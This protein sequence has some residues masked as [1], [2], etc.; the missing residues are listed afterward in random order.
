ML[1]KLRIKNFLSCED[2]TI[3]FSDDITALVGRNAAGK[4][5]ILKAIN[6]VAG[7]FSGKDDLIRELVNNEKES[8]FELLME[9]EERQYFYKLGTKKKTEKELEVTNSPSLFKIT[10]QLYTIS[11]SSK[12][13][14]FNREGKDLSVKREFTDQNTP[15]YSAAS[16]LVKA[17]Y[18]PEVQLKFVLSAHYSVSHFIHSMFAMSPIVEMVKAIYD[19]L[20]KTHYY[21]LIEPEGIDSIAIYRSSYNEWLEEYNKE[22]PSDTFNV[23]RLLHLYKENHDTFGEIVNLLGDMTLGLIVNIDISEQVIKTKKEDVLYVFQ[24]TMPN[25][26][27]VS[28]EDLSFGT[29]R[30]ISILLALLHD[31]GPVLLLEQPEDGIHV[32]LLRRFLP[33]CQRYAEEYNK[34]LIITTH[35]YEVV[36]M[37][38]PENI[39]LVSMGEEG[40]KAES[41]PE[42]DIRHIKTFMEDEG[43]LSEY[44]EILGNED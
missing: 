16:P 33:L 24:F 30:I 10:E 43:T 23:M 35:S 41:L 3:D 22:R 31:N 40:T 1:K 17:S 32:G 21:E 15:A 28:Y 4:T 20:D 44:L 2:V 38:Q 29:Q 14:V 9:I 36:D 37:L 26:E 18:Q 12:S 34:Q 19:L 25:G 13:I 6:K 27:K 7:F 11:G 5:N 39:R 8:S 42:E